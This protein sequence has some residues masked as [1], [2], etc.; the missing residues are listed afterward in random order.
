[1][2]VRAIAVDYHNTLPLRAG[3][4]QL[5]DTGELHMDLA[6]PAQATRLFQRGEYVMGLLPVA[7]SLVVPEAHFVGDY[8]IFSD[9]F[10]GSVGIFSQVP[11]EDIETLYLDHDSRSSVLLAQVLLKHYWGLSPKLVKAGKGYRERI[12]GTTA[13]VIIGDPA[14]RARSVFRYYY[15]LGE[16]WK[17]MTDLPFVFASWLSAIPLDAAFIERF[18]AAQAAGLDM[19]ESLAREFQPLVPNYNLEKYF[20]RQIRYHLTDEALR[21]RELF[22]EL[23]EPIFYGQ[24]R[25]GRQLTA[26][27]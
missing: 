4:E 23:G 12:A 9:G 13:G 26:V 2:S 27:G 18:D 11:L 8:G 16:A 5:T 6:H 19:R 3:L 1:M 10:V 15:D 21:G 14:I 25:M 17:R 22:L 7:A 20:T 24:Q